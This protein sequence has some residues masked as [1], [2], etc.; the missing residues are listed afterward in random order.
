M[1][2]DGGGCWDGWEV[3][4]GLDPTNH[5]DDLLDND[6]DGWSNYREFFEGTNPLNPNTDRDKYPLDSADPYPLI[7][8]NEDDTPPDGVIESETQGDHGE[9]SPVGPSGHRHVSDCKHSLQNRE[10]PIVWMPLLA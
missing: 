1:D 6:D 8:N 2:T 9:F 4:Y 7:P 10:G 3:F 5:K